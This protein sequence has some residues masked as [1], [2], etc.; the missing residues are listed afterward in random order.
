[1]S[2]IKVQRV[3][4]VWRV[5]AET[6]FVRIDREGGVYAFTRER[7]IRKGRKMLARWERNRPGPV[8]SIEL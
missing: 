3:G 7:A 4:R 8:E 5:W 6:D 1:M 2:V